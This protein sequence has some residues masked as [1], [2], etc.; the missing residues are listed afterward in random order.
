MMN[1]LL[2]VTLSIED[3]SVCDYS[4][5]PILNG[6]LNVTAHMKGSLAVQCT[7]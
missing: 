2:L 1:L 3:G 5:N 4:M 6:I 7:G